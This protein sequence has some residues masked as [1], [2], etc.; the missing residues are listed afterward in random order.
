MK[1]RKH[2]TITLKDNRGHLMHEIDKDFTI[3]SME[4][5]CDFR[6]GQRISE[7]KFKELMRLDCWTL[8]VK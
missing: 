7:T 4:N 5:T 8:K 6:V 1:M 2:I 3:I